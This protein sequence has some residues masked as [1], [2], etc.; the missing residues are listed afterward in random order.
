MATTAASM[1]ELL[2][3]NRTNRRQRMLL[4]TNVTPSNSKM[5]KSSNAT[6]AFYL[7]MQDVV[8]QVNAN[9]PTMKL[10]PTLTSSID[11]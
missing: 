2:E 8:Y 6:W 4:K 11:Y 9:A 1:P 5:V 7:V 3:Q 10:T